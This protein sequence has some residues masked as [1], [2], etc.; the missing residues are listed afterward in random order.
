MCIFKKNKAGK[1]T[2][3]EKDFKT[4]LDIASRYDKAGFNK[5][6][7]AVAQAWKGYD[8]MLRTKTRDDK[9]NEDL[10]KAE[11]TLDYEDLK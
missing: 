11:K 4:M 1:E 3:A 8:I 5:L 10:I 6:M 9:E 7:D 2:D